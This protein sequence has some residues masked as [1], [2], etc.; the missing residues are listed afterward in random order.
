[1]SSSYIVVVSRLEWSAKRAVVITGCDS[2]LGFTF[3]NLCHQAG[4]IVVAACHNGHNS[5][6]NDDSDSG[7][8]RLEALGQESGRL[9][10]V[11]NA[12]IHHLLS[13]LKFMK[14]MMMETLSDIRL[15]MS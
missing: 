1:M 12:P 11:R 13:L 4:F 15:M 5:S 9:F 7:S 10:V 6:D 3:A 8:G 14:M 2:G